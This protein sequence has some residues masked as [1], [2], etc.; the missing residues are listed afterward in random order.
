MSTQPRQ[1]QSELIIQAMKN[2]GVRCEYLLFL[3]EGHDLLK[4]E[5]CLTFYSA[6]GRFLARYLGG[7]RSTERICVAHRLLGLSLFPH[8]NRTLTLKYWYGIQLTETDCINSR[9][10]HFHPG[11]GKCPISLE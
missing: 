7:E 1:S 11:F 2:N 8:L 10:A 4:P 3:D 5:N 6:A 9:F